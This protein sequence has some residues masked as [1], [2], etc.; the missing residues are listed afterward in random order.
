L[1][2]LSHVFSPFCSGYFGERV[3]L[4]AQVIL[5]CDPHISRLPDVGGMAGTCSQA[6]LFSAE[7]GVSQIFWPLLALNPDPADLSFPSS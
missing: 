7:M 2:D 4:F 1:Q 5:G 6:Q 3:L